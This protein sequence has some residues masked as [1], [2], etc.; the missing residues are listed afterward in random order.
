MERNRCN[1]LEFLLY[2]FTWNTEE[3]TK[4]LR[5]LSIAAKIRIERILNTNKKRSA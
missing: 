2:Y 3:N 4:K 5:I 1:L